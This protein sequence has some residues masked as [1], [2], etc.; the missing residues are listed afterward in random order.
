M[1]IKGVSPMGP[2]GGPRLDVEDFIALGRS[3]GYNVRWEKA[4]LCPRR[5]DND[6]YKH[7]LNCTVC[8][9][10][11]GFIYYD[12]LEVEEVGSTKPL[13]ALVTGIPQQQRYTVSGLLDVGSA[14]ISLHPGMKPSFMDRITLLDSKIRV[15]EIVQKK[16]GAVDELKY[17][18]LAIN[19]GGGVIVAIDEEGVDRTSQLT[20]NGD[21]DIVWTGSRPKK[22]TFFSISYYRRAAFIVLDLP[23]MV[24][25]NIERKIGPAA[26]EFVTDLGL[27]VLAK[28]DFL[29]KDETK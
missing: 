13:R 12:P 28:L 6:I 18:A 19:D 21:G 2:F 16:D 5:T 15:S 8:E 14:Y 4:L 9:N 24:R 20:I 27:Q 17:G 25:D 22:D 11:A 3:Q 29:V 1:A 7:D 23:H 10:R 26:N